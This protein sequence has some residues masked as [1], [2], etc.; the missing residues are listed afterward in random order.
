MTSRLVT[1]DVRERIAT[2]FPEIVN[3]GIVAFHDQAC[4]VFHDRESAVFDCNEGYFKPSWRAQKDGWQMVRATT[5]FQ[6]FLLSRF[7]GITFDNFL[8]D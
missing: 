7:F 5:R 2:R 4:A 1:G 8:K 6:R 3:D